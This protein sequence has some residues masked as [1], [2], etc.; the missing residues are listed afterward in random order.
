MKILRFINAILYLL[1]II[2][3]ILDLTLHKEIFKNCW[4]SF[5]GIASVLLLI[6]SII[7]ARQ[8]HNK[9]TT[10][11]FT[12]Y[13]WED[14]AFTLEDAALRKARIFRNGVVSCIRQ[15][16]QLVNNGK[17]SDWGS[18][19]VSALQGGQLIQLAH[20]LVLLVALYLL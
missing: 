5:F 16:T 13:W 17:V 14:I 6:I 11:A 7:Q 19:G 15:I 20:S 2:F 4:T 9:K 10:S 1:A 8:L 3:G 18:V 12:R